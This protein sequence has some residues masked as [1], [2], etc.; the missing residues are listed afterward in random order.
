MAK[1]RSRKVEVEDTS[2]YIFYNTITKIMLFVDAHLH[3]DAVS[4]FDLCGFKHRDHWKIF[5]ETEWQPAKG[6]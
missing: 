1:K 6:K 3:N 2:V 4:K 5:L